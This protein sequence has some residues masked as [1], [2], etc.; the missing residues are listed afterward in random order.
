MVVVP[1][2]DRRVRDADLLRDRR[3]RA[4]ALGVH[5]A[6]E[7]GGGEREREGGALAEDVAAGVDRG[8]VAQHRRAE[9]DPG[10]RRPGPAER[11]LAVGGAVAVVEHRARRAPP[12]DQPQVG[13]RGGAAQAAGGGVPDERGGPQQRGELGGPGQATLD[14][15]RSV[16]RSAP[17]PL[18]PTLAWPVRPRPR[19]QARRASS[20]AATAPALATPERLHPGVHGDR[21]QPGEQRPHRRGQPVRLVAQHQRDPRGQLGRE[22]RR[23]AR[24]QPVHRE[25]R[26][27]QRRAALLDGRRPQHRR[28]ERHPGRRLDHQRVDRGQPAAGEQHARPARP[29][30]RCAG[31]CRRSPGW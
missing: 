22:Q 15:P 21:Q 18:R 16:S 8:H 7:A 19:G 9:L 30:W 26:L 4:L 17:R 24:V 6:R 25:P 11:V 2:V 27:D 13:D 12:G 10:E 23:P 20:K 5:H 31:S 1:I 28:P 3:H 29:R 14:H